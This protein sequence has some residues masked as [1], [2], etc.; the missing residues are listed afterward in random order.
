MGFNR[1]GDLI[2]SNDYEKTIDVHFKKVLEDF[3]V[4]WVLLKQKETLEKRNERLLHELEC[5]YVSLS[6]IKI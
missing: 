2:L 1:K 6:Q 3:R 5:F 4:E